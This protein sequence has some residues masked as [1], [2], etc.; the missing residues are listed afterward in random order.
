M[1]GVDLVGTWLPQGRADGATAGLA[2]S[3]TMMQGDLEVLPLAGACCDVVW[4]R[5]VL[6][7]ETLWS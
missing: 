3:I 5:D 6:S 1:V 4:C 2:G 7:W